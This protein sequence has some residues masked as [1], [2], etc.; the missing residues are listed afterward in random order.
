VA[1]TGER[2]RPFGPT[3]NLDD[4]LSTLTEAVLALAR[5]LEGDRPTGQRS[6]PAKVARA[7]RLA[8]EILVTGR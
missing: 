2:A 3:P 8:E 5:G 1:E 7:A 6:D 4:R